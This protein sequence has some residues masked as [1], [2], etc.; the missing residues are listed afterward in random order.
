MERAVS[1]ETAW[2][3]AAAGIVVPALLTAVETL[4]SGRASCIEML[5]FGFWVACM[6]IL[7]RILMLDDDH[8]MEG[9][10]IYTGI[11]LNMALILST[12]ISKSNLHEIKDT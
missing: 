7:T 8:L 11:I 6:I 10:V 3:Y 5:L 2:M 1:F 12:S 4:R 9:L